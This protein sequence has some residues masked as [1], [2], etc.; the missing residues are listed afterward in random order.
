MGLCVEPILEVEGERGKKIPLESLGIETC[1][2][3]KKS[4][5]WKEIIKID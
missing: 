3:L 5:G 1:R 2:N 4:D